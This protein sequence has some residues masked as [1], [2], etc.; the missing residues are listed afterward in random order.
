MKPFVS[1]S[2]HSLSDLREARS[3]CSKRYLRLAR[4][5]VR[6]ELTPAVTGAPKQN[7]VGVGIGEKLVRGRRTGVLSVKLYVRFKYPEGHLL[8]RER[9]PKTTYGLPV[10]VVEV[11]MLRS[12]ATTGRGVAA[13][14]S[15]ATVTASVPMPNPRVKRRP[16]CPGCSVGFKD[17]GLLRLRAGTFGALVADANGLYVL[18]N[19]HVLADENR[20]ATGAPIFQPG[21]AD[22]E[23][24]KNNQIA[25]LSRF[26]P[27][28]KDKPNRVDC[29]VAK[30]NDVSAVS[31]E[32]LHIGLPKSKGSASMDMNVHKFGRS[33]DYTA[34]RVIDLEAEVTLEF[35]TGFYT[36]QRQIMISGEAG[37]AFA[38]RGD[39][40]ALVLERESQKVVGL[41]FGVGKSQEGVVFAVANHINDVLQSLD[42][43]LA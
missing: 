23:K 35:E 18:S 39:S 29:A 17:P 24:S 11:G 36:F 15:T 21:L 10:D 34:G 19:N 40:G 30:V 4:K 2:T 27:L 12:L 42:V 31:N 20:L 5:A 43:S 33:T 22:D 6:Q 26:E 38:V 7:V 32:V 1:A 25:L 28:K 3:E 16:A 37:D 41:L 9:L 8:R 13:R 14:G